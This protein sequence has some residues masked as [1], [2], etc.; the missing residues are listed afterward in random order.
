MEPRIQ[1]AQSSDGVSIAY[2]AMGKGTPIV[3][4]PLLFSH[5]QGEWQLPTWR[6][7][8]ERLSQKRTLVR[9][10][11][12]GSGLS[13]RD[14][15][16]YSLDALVRDV[17]A[18]VDRLQLTT[19]ALHGLVFSAP[20]AIAYAARHPERVSRLILYCPLARASD[21]VFPGAEALAALRDANWE[22]YTETLA[23]MARGWSAGQPARRAAALFRESI[24]P[25]GLRALADASAGWDVTPLLPQVKCPALI[26]WRRQIATLPVEWAREFVTRLPDSR[27]VL[28]EG[29]VF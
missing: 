10:D 6:P 17:E 15:T 28:L 27:L 2:W 21:L 1:Y 3:Q 8:F 26:I 9:Y 13:Q 25:Q 16:D 22:L 20:V 23:H 14:V 24:T 11:R 29:E 5:I 19:L 7:F 18:V 4:T 12:R